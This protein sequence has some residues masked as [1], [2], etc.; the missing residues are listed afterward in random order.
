LTPTHRA[1]SGFL[2]TAKTGKPSVKATLGADS[3]WE[4][5]ERNPAQL[6]IF[7]AAMTSLTAKEIGD[8][9]AC[10]DFAAIRSIVD[11]GGGLG[12]MLFAI[13]RRHPHIERG[14]L[15]DLPSVVKDVVV[16]DDLKARVEVHGGSFLDTETGI[17][18]GADA[19]IMK[20]IIHDWDDESVRARTRV[21]AETAT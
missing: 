5:N 8:V 17:P 3:L 2:E 4:Y 20:H 13:L 19:Y 21:C 15:Y 16:P 10:Y 11:I 12:S 6:K 14:H 7:N 1:W 9:L 18:A